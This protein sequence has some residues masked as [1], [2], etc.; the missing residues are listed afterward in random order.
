MFAKH[1]RP[2]SAPIGIGLLI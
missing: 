2:S 1:I